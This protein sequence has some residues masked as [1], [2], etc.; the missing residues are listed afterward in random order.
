MDTMTFISNIIGSIAW[1]L[2]V[3]IAVLIF[4]LQLIELFGS[5]TR[6]VDRIKYIKHG[7]TEINTTLNE[8][9]TKT[10]HLPLEP[11]DEKEIKKITSSKENPKMIIQKAYDSL[12]ST[13]KESLGISTLPHIEL[14]AKLKDEIP[15]DTFNIF[16]QMK[17]IRNKVA[18]EPLGVTTEAST[19]Y[20]AS[21]L[22]L[23]KYFK[24]LKK[25]S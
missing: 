5:I 6:L 16:T 21:A 4:K 10:K 17:D 1:P 20:S 2:I 12:E 22:R 18:F 3:I 8:V 23:S 11:D 13:A 7:E 14:E 24:D 19:D 15:E 25:R 9:K